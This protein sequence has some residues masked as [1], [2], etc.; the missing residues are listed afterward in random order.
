MEYDF[1]SST[2]HLMSHVIR[3]YRKNVDALIQAYDVY[4]GQ[5]PLLLQLAHQ[6]GQMQ[7]DLAKSLHLTPAT[8]TVMI[9]RMERVGLIQRKADVH[10]QRISRIFLTEKGRVALSAVRSALQKIESSCFENFSTEEKQLFH[11]LLQELHTKMAE[12]SN[13]C[14][15][16]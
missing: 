6:D 8:L 12:R 14:P 2:L 16:E 9:T 3:L 1:S 13:L 10:D 11:R 5:P 7:K 4:P 15:T